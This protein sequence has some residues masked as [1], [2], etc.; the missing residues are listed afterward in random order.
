MDDSVT[1]FP[2]AVHFPG[3]PGKRN[4]L[5]EVQPL[6]KGDLKKAKFIL[7]AVQTISMRVQALGYRCHLLGPKDVSWFILG[8]PT[9]PQTDI[10][11]S[12]DL[13]DGATLDD[14]FQKLQVAKRRGNTFEYTDNSRSCK[15]VITQVSP[16]ESLGLEASLAYGLTQDGIPIY[17]PGHTL[18]SHLTQ[19]RLHN[20]ISA[21]YGLPERTYEQIVPVLQELSKSSVDL[22]KVFL[23]GVKRDQ[24]DELVKAIC[25]SHPE[26]KGVLTTL[27]FAFLSDPEP[28]IAKGPILVLEDNPRDDIVFEA[29]EMTVKVLC[30]AGYSCAVSGMVASYLQVNDT[31]L[32]LPD[33]TEITVFSHEDIDTIQ[34]LVSKH[35]LFYTAKMK[36]PG[37][38]KRSPVLLYRIHGRGRG[39]RKWKMCKIHLVMTQE[40]ISHETKEGLPLVPL[41]TLLVDPLRLWHDHYVDE[42]QEAGKHA[43][44]FE[45]LRKAVNVE[46]CPSSWD[47]N[48]LEDELKIARMEPFFSTS[49]ESQDA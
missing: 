28:V 48:F 15:I 24:L 7:S 20:A 6:K 22:R 43:P 3:G 45:A 21:D 35:K 9:I 42:S 4:K 11:F 47:A 29:A 17:N 37:A 26:L 40:A 25:G 13:T 16:A 32:P 44:Y 5:C 36:V 8:A 10:W 27:G 46:D 49:K 14:L 23:D 12:V 31:A 2:V 38:D 19:P 30:E 39:T 18:V 41:S 34:R 1:V 33:C